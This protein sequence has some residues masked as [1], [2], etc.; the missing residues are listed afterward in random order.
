MTENFYTFFSP[1][2]YYKSPQA[3]T[4]RN[5][6]GRSWYRVLHLTSKI[7]LFSM[8]RWN[9][10]PSSVFPDHYNMGFFNTWV[11]YLGL[12][13]TRVNKC[14]LDRP[15]TSSTSL[16]VT[17]RWDWGQRTG[18]L[19]IKCLHLLF[20]KWVLIALWVFISW[21]LLSTYHVSYLPLQA[22]LL[23]DP[24]LGNPLCNLQSLTSVAE[25]SDSLETRSSNIWSVFRYCTLA[26]DILTGFVC[27]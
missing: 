7:K 6:L 10:L 1:S 16:S 9:T 5:R 18:L 17:T 13:K 21:V 25:G 23:W 22:I 12:F 26:F 24:L 3:L 20:Q 27:A 15:A 14:I 2:F 4:S 19:L 8:L 11:V